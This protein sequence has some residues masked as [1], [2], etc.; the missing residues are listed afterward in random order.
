MKD[1]TTRKIANTI[2]KTSKTIHIGTAVLLSEQP[3]NIFT[4]LKAAIKVHAIA[5]Q[6]TKPF[7]SFCF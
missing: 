5:T 6:R 1:T 3:A 4:V 7:A 2:K